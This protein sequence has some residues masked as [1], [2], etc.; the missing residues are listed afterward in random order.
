MA[1]T[2]LTPVAATLRGHTLAHAPSTR[3]TGRV[4][5]LGSSLPLLSVRS[6]RKDREL[7]RAT[8]TPRSWSLR[9]PPGESRVVVDTGARVYAFGV[10]SRDAHR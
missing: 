7:G 1:K 4:L 9:V 6:L 3:V 8:G 5:R 10:F 2:A